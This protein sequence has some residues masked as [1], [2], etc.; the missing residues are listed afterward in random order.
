[1]NNGGK[2]QLKFW[3]RELTGFLLTL[4]VV[5]FESRS[6]TT[7]DNLRGREGN[8]PDHQLRSLSIC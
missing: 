1:M 3:G 8:N 4:N 7:R 5:I 6:Q 2:A